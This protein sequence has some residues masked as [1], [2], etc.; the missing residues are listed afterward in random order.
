ML[1]D[2]EDMTPGDLIGG[3]WS[4]KGFRDTGRV[5]G[6][7]KGEAGLLTRRASTLAGDAARLRKGLFDDK[8]RV[9]PLED[10]LVPEEWP[11]QKTY[12]QLAARRQANEEVSGRMHAKERRLMGQR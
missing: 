1:S 10:W 12:Q 8:L 7:S 2:R 6:S 3:G 11:A 9:M 4:T 5:G